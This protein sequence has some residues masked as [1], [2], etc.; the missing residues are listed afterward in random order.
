MCIMIMLFFNANDLCY[1]IDTEKNFK[2]VVTLILLVILHGHSERTACH[3][4]N[5]RMK[6]TI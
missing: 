4:S 2:I 1:H 5:V 3:L 6:I